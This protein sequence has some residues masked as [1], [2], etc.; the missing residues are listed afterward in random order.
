MTH[1]VMNI[2]CDGKPCFKYR[3]ED[4]VKPGDTISFFS[5]AFP[6]RTYGEVL[7][8]KDETVVVRKLEPVFDESGEEPQQGHG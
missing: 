3:F 6:G 4:P 1:T 5:F 7:S 8:V 2:V